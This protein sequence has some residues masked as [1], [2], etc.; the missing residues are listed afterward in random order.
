MDA[1]SRKAIH[2]AMVRL[3]DGDRAA[4]DVLLDELWPVILSFARR[5][6]G[7]G[8]DA[9]DVAQEVFVRICSRIT[10]FDR[11]RDGLAWAFGIARY[12]IMTQRRRQQRRR[13]VNDELV[14]ET[15]PDGAASAEQRLIDGEM[16][17]AFDQA[18]GALSDD[19]RMALG[20]GD[21]RRAEGISAPAARK[22]KQRALAR[23][24]GLWRTIN[25]E[26]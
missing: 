22:R 9:E 12:E 18:V 7:G 20:L 25:G 11:A 19:D 24:R 13:E 8:A 14:L 2:E 10:E 3:A 6:V 5:G 17:A 21:G 16:E 23:L 15:E 1:G 4:F 26:S